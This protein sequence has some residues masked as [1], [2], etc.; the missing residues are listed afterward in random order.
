MSC[1]VKDEG[2]D[3]ACEGDAHNS[4]IGKKDTNN[5]NICEMDL[6]S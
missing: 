4:S 2:S 6:R 5:N 1:Q 3:D